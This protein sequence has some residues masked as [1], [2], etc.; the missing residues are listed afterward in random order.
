[1]KLENH[2]GYLLTWQ[3]GQVHVESFSEAM[4]LVDAKHDLVQIGA[5]QVGFMSF[6][7]PPEWWVEQLAGHADEPP[8]QVR[9]DYT[10]NADSIMVQVQM[11][12][13]PCEQAGHYHAEVEVYAIAD[14]KKVDGKTKG[15]SL[16]ILEQL[17][18][19]VGEKYDE[20]EEVWIKPFLEHALELE[21]I[22]GPPKDE[23]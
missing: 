9:C 7:K 22:H 21:G 19:L 1:M 2:E 10:Y 16:L 6:D 8:D 11:A 20:L 3:G 18:R 23:S 14:M 17:W 4:R 13:Y 5:K 12:C 15:K